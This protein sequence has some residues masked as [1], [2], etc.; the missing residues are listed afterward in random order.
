MKT[1]SKL[2]E[3]LTG[4]AAAHRHPVNIG[5]HLVGIPVIM[6]GVFVALSWVSIGIDGFTFDLAQ[7]AVIILFVFYMTLDRIFALAFLLIAFPMALA[8]AA[9]GN[10]PSPVAGW[11]AAAAFF[12]GYLAQFIGHAVEK[13][14]P[15][16][17]KHPIQ[18]NI[19][20]PFFTIVEIF[21]LLGLRQAL[22]DE[23]QERISK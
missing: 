17:I 10:L 18:A 16:V 15:V 12:G 2:M 9:V 19:A 5:V 14:A 23:V 3:M 13:S 6:F 21:Q 8:A 4:Y 7:L 22:F 1:N 20:A 11:I